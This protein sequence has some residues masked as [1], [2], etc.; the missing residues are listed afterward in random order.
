MNETEYRLILGGMTS[1][2]WVVAEC[3]TEE[4]PQVRA[5]RCF[6]DRGKASAFMARLKASPGQTRKWSLDT[7][8]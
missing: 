7:N 8:P 4:R 6:R 2:G 3:E 5:V 1:G